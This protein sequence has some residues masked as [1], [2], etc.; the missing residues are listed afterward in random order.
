[1]A[2]EGI[3]PP[4]RAEA[5]VLFDEGTSLAQQ[6]RHVEACPK[7]AASYKLDP[8]MGVLFRLAQCY[9]ATGKFASAWITYV[10]V[11]EMALAAR[12]ADREK[13]ARDQ[14]RSDQAEGPQDVAC[15]SPTMCAPSPA[16]R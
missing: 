1:M 13:H 6:G 8:G 15:S 5:R 11:A 16:S 7:L 3:E 12:R 10:E 9:E 4:K 2:D 14:A